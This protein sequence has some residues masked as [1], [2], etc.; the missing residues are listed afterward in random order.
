[1]ANN[2]ADSN[3]TLEHSAKKKKNNEVTKKNRKVKKQLLNN[4][5]EY[6]NNNVELEI[7][8][9]CFDMNIAFT[10]IKTILN[11]EKL[12]DISNKCN[13]LNFS[14]RGD[15]GNLIYMFITK[16]LEKE[17][18]KDKYEIF[19]KGESDAAESSLMLFRKKRDAAESSLMLFRKKRDAAESSLMLFREKRD[20]KICGV[21]FSFKKITG[22]ACI[23]LDWSK[24][25]DDIKKDY[26]TNDIIIMNLKS[27][28]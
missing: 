4:T 20:M 19:H 13:S 23:A 1:M 11:D 15:G 14:C 3:A 22:K 24:N 2:V 16:F 28:N 27:C 5:P 25:K 12:Q 21:P 9:N 18:D 6:S 8:N 7:K 26:F 17:L 10:Y